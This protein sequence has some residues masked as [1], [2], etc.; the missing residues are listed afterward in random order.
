VKRKELPTQA[1]LEQYEKQAQEL[2][3]AHRLG[4]AE[5]IWCIKNDHPRFR[6]MLH[7][8]IRNAAFTL[9]DAQLIVAYWNYFG[10]WPDL[11]AYVEAVTRQGSSVSRFESAVDA[12]VD[13]DVAALERS[14]RADPG[15]IRARSTRTHHSTLLHYV[16]A[17]GTE[18]QRSPGNA[19]QVAKILLDAGA[20]VN[21]VGEM[22]GGTTVL[23][24]VATSVHPAKA[25]VQEP[26]MEFLL[27]RGATLEGAVAPDYTRGSVVNA[28]LAN[29]RPNAAAFLGRRGARLD[30]DGAA[31][32]GRL[33]VVKSFFNQDR[34]LK[35]H[36]T[37][38]QMETGFTWACGC[39]RT[40]VVEFLL[41][42]GVNMN[43]TPHGETG[44]H[45]AAYGGQRNIVKLLLER[46]SPLALKDKTF[47]GTPLAWALYGWAH[48]PEAT[49]GRYYEVAALLV[50]AGAPVEPEFLA[51]EKVRSDSTMLVALRGEPSRQQKTNL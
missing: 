49:G 26:L 40:D 12:I 38:E 11:A 34:S 47:D 9:A 4:D 23:G 35:A 36:A 41:E 1:P 44:L 14:L 16:G 17:N 45:W 21:A 31:G 2:V 51:D 3:D 37:K 22:Y 15:L 30:L 39:G 32:V 46:R 33:D 24:L 27:A 20:E 6:P 48:P 8:E 43:S 50:A 29:G 19:V 7:S 10:N 42:M 18:K 28:C 13:G 5:T 25:G